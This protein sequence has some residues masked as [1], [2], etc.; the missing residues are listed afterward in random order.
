M[1]TFMATPQR[2]PARPAA[3]RPL[4]ALTIDVEDWPQST[5]DHALPITER[6]V[7][8]T[9]RM[10]EL[11]AQHE[12]RGTFFVLG[13]LAKKF[14]HVVREIAD[15]GHEVASHGYSHKPVFAIGPQAFA[16]ELDHSVK[17]LEDLCGRRITG[18]RAPDFS[19]TA[20]SL[21]AL[22]I[23]AEHGLEY[24]SSIMPVKMRR[25]GID[26][27]PREIHRLPN[28]LVEV[29]LS[30]VCWM[31]RRWPVAG[32]GYLR[33]YP[34]QVTA[35]AVHRLQ[36][37]GLPAIVYLHPYE[38]DAAEIAETDLPVSAR[39][40]VT[41]GLNRKHIPGRLAKL[42][43]HFQFGPLVEVVRGAVTEEVTVRSMST[44]I[45]AAAAH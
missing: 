18:Y 17:L 5:L 7:T 3:R 38:L 36:A 27:F 13:R 9:R 28:G 10:L 24:D 41:Q 2:S 35:H 4:H 26:R 1:T 29:P 21:W 31:G 44:A 20:E 30:T 16:D 37:E 34:Y 39:T 6:A 8:N 45:F 42:L 12:V 11:F 33:L 32:G 22:D 40:R 14:P 19:I 23:L 15:A 25:Y 43:Q